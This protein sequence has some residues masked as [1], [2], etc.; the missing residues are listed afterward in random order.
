[1]A[2]RAELGTIPS[3][4]WQRAQAVYSQICA[5]C[6]AN[7]PS[8][9][10]MSPRVC[11]A[12]GYHGHAKHQCAVHKARVARMT[13]RELEMDA[14]YGYVRPTCVVATSTTTDR[15]PCPGARKRTLV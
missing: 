12:C 15:A 8:G 7:G 10:L 14:A 1:M 6:N 4:Q 3:D 11:S 5:L 13:Q 2:L 9:S